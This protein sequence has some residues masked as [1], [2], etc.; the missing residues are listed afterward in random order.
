MT[1]KYENKIKTV[2]RALKDLENFHEQYVVGGFIYRYGFMTGARAGEGSLVAMSHAGTEDEANRQINR[3]N[4]VF[5]K[6]ATTRAQIE[7]D[8]DMRTWY[9]TYAIDYPFNKMEEGSDWNAQ[10]LQTLF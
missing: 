7:F 2:N 1:S 10:F 9:V 8:M 4:E 5:H 6:Y 3:L